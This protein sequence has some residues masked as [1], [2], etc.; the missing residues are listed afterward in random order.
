VSTIAGETAFLPCNISLPEQHN[1][2]DSV[3]LV[4]WLREEKQGTT[5]IYRSVTALDVKLMPPSKQP[6]AI[7]R[8][9]LLCTP[10][11]APTPK[12]ES[13]YC[14]S[15]KISDRFDAAAGKWA[16]S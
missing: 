10:L 2:G 15:P 12:K 16:W 4:L 7:A 9:T 6:A 5:P 1:Q 11:H 3:I 13:K 8:S 14:R